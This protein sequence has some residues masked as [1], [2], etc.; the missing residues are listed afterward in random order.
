MDGLA[1]ERREYRATESEHG[2]GLMEE[3]RR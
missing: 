2:A 1:R 3:A